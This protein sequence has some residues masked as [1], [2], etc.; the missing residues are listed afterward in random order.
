MSAGLLYRPGAAP[1]PA[2]L[3]QGFGTLIETW[4]GLSQPNRNRVTLERRF[5]A[6]ARACGLGEDPALFLEELRKA[7]PGSRAFEAAANLVPNRET[8]FFRD[9]GQLHGFVDQ[10]LTTSLQETSGPIRILSA[11]CAT[12][13]EAY[14]LA[15]LCFENLH[16]FY[17]RQVAI[18]GVDVSH[19]AIQRARAGSYGAS[20]LAKAGRGP[21]G[22]QERYFRQEGDAYQVKSF[23]R[24]AVTFQQAN[25]V[26][27]ASLAGMG[28][29]DAIVCR[30]VLIYFDRTTLEATV[31]RLLGL[32]RPGGVLLLGH[33][34][35]GFVSHL[36]HLRRRHD[37]QVWFERRDD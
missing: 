13:E 2:E 30:N 9:V 27:P 5:L 11:G 7:E 6:A 31:D 10:L 25:L 8:S 29:Y 4:F 26:D 28:G 32:L 34:E 22:W 20:A 12:G 1:I 21:E 16:R 19:E 3:L 14:S 35:S 17:C 36:D 23:L 33:A 37:D 24:A 15:M 18:H